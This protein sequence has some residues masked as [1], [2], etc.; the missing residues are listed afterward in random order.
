MGLWL[1]ANSGIAGTIAVN[2]TCQL[3]N[4]TDPDVLES[5]DTLTTPFD[6]LYTFSNTDQFRI[7]GVLDATNSGGAS[8]SMV[9]SQYTATYLGNSFGTASGA[10]TISLRFL[11]NFGSGISSG[12]F[13]EVLYGAFGGPVASSGTTASGQAF[14]GGVALPLM[15][16]FSPQPALFSDF[17]SGLPITGLNNPML[18]D[19]QFTASFGAG[20]QPG[21]FIILS[22]VPV[23]LPEPVPEPATLVYVGFGVLTIIAKRHV[24]FA[25]LSNSG[26]TKEN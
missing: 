9:G 14:I 22:T 5:N 4:C 1:T 19:V 26:V 24:K 21:A 3:G 17:V 12:T 25:K 18:V 20:S 13:F 6:F 10:D 2:G 16:P 7:Q 11:Q 15:G 23:S 8:F